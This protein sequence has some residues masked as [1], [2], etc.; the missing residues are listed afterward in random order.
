MKKILALVLCLS[1]L[2]LQG[3]CAITDDFAEKT[4]DKNK[5]I[6]INLSGRG[7]KD[8]EVILEKLDEDKAGEK[9]E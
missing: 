9:D 2:H 3:F 8:L 7:D 6:V 5:I 1:F 4:L